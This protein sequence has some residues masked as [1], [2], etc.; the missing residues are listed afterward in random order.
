MTA[1]A[2]LRPSGGPTRVGELLLPTL[3]VLVSRGPASAA[4]FSTLLPSP[5]PHLKTR[6]CP[7]PGTRVTASHCS[8]SRAGQVNS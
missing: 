7:S 3:V 6:S 8:T 4:S 2:C 5:P 1:A